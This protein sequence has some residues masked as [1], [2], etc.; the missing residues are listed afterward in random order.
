MG[1]A[2]KVDGV[3]ELDI[4]NFDKTVI[5]SKDI[6]MVELYTSWC[7]PCKEAEPQY[8]S[9]ANHMSKYPFIH[10]GRVDADFNR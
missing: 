4:Y 2:Y 7:E 5:Q 10:F 9:V 3:Y 8:K 1:T 6:W